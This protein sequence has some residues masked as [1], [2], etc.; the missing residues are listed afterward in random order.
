LGL[1]RNAIEQGRQAMESIRRRSRGA[2]RADLDVL[3]V[4]AGPAGL[5]ATLCAKEHELRY[6]TVEQD[7]LGGAVAQFP[8]GKLVMTSPA[9]LP[10]VGRMFF[11]ETSKEELLRFWAEVERTTGLG[12]RY[13]ERVESIAPRAGGFLV[14]TTRAE[15]APRSVLLAIGRRGTPR[16]LDVPGE[17]LPKVVYRLIDPA[18]YRGRRVLVVGGGDS[19]LEAAAAVAVEH[20]T[21]VTLSHRSDAFSRAKLANRDRVDDLARRGRLRVLLGSNVTSIGAHHVDLVTG[22]RRHR[23]ANDAVIVCIGGVLPT[24]F[25]ERVGVDVE[26]KHGTV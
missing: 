17:E 26:T 21:D 5:A 12:I 18:Q 15:Y 20:G 3:I 25:L 9:T 14:K 1:I 23:L 10:I 22:E 24:A 4:G 7:A 2:E 6:V 16:K 13:R 11:R 19:A 8:R